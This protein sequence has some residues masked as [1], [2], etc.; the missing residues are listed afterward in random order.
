MVVFD[1][2]LV[3]DEFVD[4][5][6]WCGFSVRGEPSAE[7]YL[8]YAR[9]DLEEG[10]SARH[11]VNALSNVKRALHLRVEDLCLGFGFGESALKRNKS[12]IPLVSYLRDCGVVAP[13]VL[14]LINSSRNSV[15]HGFVI[16]ERVDVRVFYGVVE[17]FL[18][19]TNRWVQR[20]PCE[21][22]FLRGCFDSSGEYELS[23]ADFMWQRGEV[24]LSY[25]RTGEYGRNCKSR[26][27]LVVSGKEFKRWSK[28]LLRNNY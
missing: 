24:V 12:F 20:Q 7:D 14:E 2:G 3:G 10:D 25:S 27:Q 4:E 1:P 22:R 17:L 18:E 8:S 15:E 9:L 21:M 16:P 11:R 5:Y 13:E 23:S 6:S 19:A 28:L 26:G